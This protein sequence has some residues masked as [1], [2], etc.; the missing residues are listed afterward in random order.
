MARKLSKDEAVDLA[1]HDAAQRAGIDPG[2]VRVAST[3][4]TEFPN[5]ALGAARPGE[6]S[7]DMVTPGWTIRVDAGSLSLEYRA[8]PRQIRLAGFDGGNHVVFPD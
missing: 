2:Q 4:D 8:A 7:A 5:S 6:M 1:V 3:T